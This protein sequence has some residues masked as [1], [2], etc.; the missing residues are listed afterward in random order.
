MASRDLPGD[1]GRR[2]RSE[3]LPDRWVKTL[4]DE[5]RC[6]VQTQNENYQKGTWSVKQRDTAERP[7]AQW[8]SLVTET[9]RPKE[10]EL[11]WKFC[12][13]QWRSK[14][15]TNCPVRS[16]VLT[17]QSQHQV[18]TNLSDWDSCLSPCEKCVIL[19]LFSP[20]LHDYLDH[21]FIRCLCLLTNWSKFCCYLLDRWTHSLC[22]TRDSDITH[23]RI[24]TS[25]CSVGLR[26]ITQQQASPG[27]AVRG[28]NLSEL[29]H[30]LSVFSNQ[31]RSSRSLLLGL[32]R[33]SS[34]SS[35]TCRT[36]REHQQTQVTSLTGVGWYTWVSENRLIKYGRKR[37]SA[38][39][40]VH[41][42]STSRWWNCPTFPL[43]FSLAK[44]EQEALRSLIGC[45]TG[46]RRGR[47]R[48]RL[49]G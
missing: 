47:V 15:I 7:C 23:I 26:I 34:S 9:R 6:S 1:R 39:L 49:I 8:H 33:S 18:I 42:N 32:R 11:L 38:L 31:R 24:W 21:L 3:Q 14:K 12:R 19:L 45:P 48:R 22:Y 2:R 46:R 28:T 13:R 4:W 16:Y 10:T 40:T 5:P 44:A 36:Q 17:A 29:L 27:A 30:Q 37:L 35:I 41:V 20:R 25:A 43:L